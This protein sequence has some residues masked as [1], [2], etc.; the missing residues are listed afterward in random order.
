M[1]C[2]PEICQFCSQAGHTAANCRKLEYAKREPKGNGKRGS[3][4]RRGG[5]TDKD[6]TA[7]ADR[8]DKKLHRLKCYYCEGP[9]I[10]ANCP[11]KSKDAP[12]PTTGEKKGGGM[13]AKTRVDKPAGAGLWACDDTDA[14]VSGSGERWISDSGAT[15]NMTPDPT[16]FERYETAPPGRTVEMGDGTLL[17]VAGYGDLRLKIEQDD[18]DGG[19]T[20]DLVLRRA[21]HVP[22]LRHNLLSAAQLSATFEHPMQLWP[23]AAVFRCPRNGQSVIFRKS[24]RRLFEATARRS[25]IMDQASAKALVVAKPTTCDIM[26]FHQLVGHPGEDITRRTAQVA[27]LRL[28]GGWNACEKCSE[29]RVLRHAVPKSTETRADKRAGRVFIDL[30]GPFHV[31]SLAGSRFAMLCVDDFSRYKIVAFMAKKSDATA[32]LRAIIAKYFAPAGLNIGV[33]R[34]DN[35]GEFQGA[36]QSLLA[37]LG[38]KHERTPPYTP[39]YNG[40]AERT[41]GLLR[42]KTVALL[43][44][45]TEGASER[46]W[47]EAMAY[48]CDMSNKCVTDSLDHDKTP[49]EMWHGRLPAF[50]TLLPFGT[51]GY[52]RV[53]KPAHK[54]ASR[55]AKCILLGTAGPHDVNDHRPRGTFRV[56]DLT[57][58]AIIWRQAV[59]WHPVAGAGGDIP[60]AAATGGGIKGDENHSP[61]LEELAVRMGTLGAELGSEEQGASGESREIPEDIP[62][63]PEL[64]EE[65]LEHP[66]LPEMQLDVDEPETG[67]RTLE[68]EELEPDWQAEQRDAPA[69]LRK[70][71]NSFTDNLHPV[72]PSRTRS[73]GRG[74]E[75]E[76]V[77]GGEGAGNDHALCC[78]VPREQTLPALLGAV[79][80]KRSQISLESRRADHAIALQAA[81]TMPTGLASYLPDEP[82][83]LHE[84]KVSPEWPQWRGALKLEMDGQIA[85]GVW[86]VVDRPKGK[87][88]LGTKTVFKRKVGQDGRVEKYKCRFV[89]KGFRQ[90]KGI[91]YQES[92]SPTP[93]Q[94]S[95]RMALAVMALL[96]WEGRQLDVEMA[97]LEADVTEELYVELPDGYRDSPNQVGRRQKAM[98]GL[99]HAGLL[100]SKKFGGELIAKGFERSQADPCVFRRKHLGKAVVII[101]VYVDDLLVLSETKQDEHQALEDLRSSF[102][103]KDLGEVS[104]YLGCHITR[105]RKARTVRF[106]QQRYAQT[107][108]ERFEVWKTSV[109][110]ISTG[111]A[112]LSKADGPQNDAEIAE[113]R[114]IPYREAV[115]ALMW[116]ANMTRPDLV[117]TAHTLAKFG[118]NPGPEHWKAVM[119]ALQYL[120]RTASLGVTY[121]GATEDNMKL[122]AWVDADHA[123]CPDTRRSVSG[124]AVML[125]GG[126]VSWF[127]R[128]QRITATA[129]SESEY[130]ALAEVVN[131]LRF[132]RQVKAF[133][134]PPIDY[135]IR[136]HEDNEGAIKMAE[137]RFSSRRTRHIDVKHHMVR[138]AVDGGIIRV[139]YVKSRG[140][141]ADVLTKAID[142]KSFEKHARFLLNVR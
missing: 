63:E 27:G 127:S 13:L 94:S 136:V 120:K 129:T 119:K 96:D 50:D 35:G 47:A 74:R 16:G 49:Y 17:P 44:G 109:I 57:T 43:R 32:V 41:L 68:D 104:Y 31:E 51:V 54:L 97:F 103:I 5:K 56:R 108:A 130:V 116:V 110:P 87:T 99:M 101:V 65:L 53:E 8:G 125:G 60:L 142:A 88:V 126:A 15:E 117:F 9:H 7:S 67:L 135:N 90:I 46:L 66:E 40:V 48:A 23:R 36:F 137:N 24:A 73:G 113:M 105:D 37:E 123:S 106:D 26:M 132:L 69:A 22:G 28:T 92:S 59:T 58:G 52:R 21:A 10:Q 78:N 79:G 139:E 141:H 1:V 83:T 19:Q 18:A 34:T 71:H 62:L 75:N 134:V 80:V 112:P 114:G 122:T 61:Q 100:W 95:I 11:E 86:K 128:A 82:T 14:T 111:K 64:P 55:G 3:G 118:D 93:T 85:R 33:I 115:G 98:Y 6:G 89:A 131:E 25:A 20:R 70:V 84:A 12:R 124:G 29:A 91:H 72:L 45:V 2:P 77:G 30:A 42:D 102:P 138:D 140:Q 39:Q 107:V 121:G 76:S 38:I 81:S 4:R 133:M